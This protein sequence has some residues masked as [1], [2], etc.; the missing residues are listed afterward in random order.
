MTVTL[1]DLDFCSILFYFYIVLN[2]VIQLVIKAERVLFEHRLFTE[3]QI[4]NKYTY[5]K[6]KSFL[7]ATSKN[8]A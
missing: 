6:R 4:S 2:L 8:S 5:V 1:I 3:T 7:M